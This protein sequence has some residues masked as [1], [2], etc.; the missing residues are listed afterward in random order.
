MFHGGN[1]ILGIHRHQALEV[2]RVGCDSL[3]VL[4]CGTNRSHATRLSRFDELAV[5]GVGQTTCCK[6]APSDAHQHQALD[7]FRVAVVDQH[8]QPGA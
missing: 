8:G 4:F 2:I 5:V 7:D 3:L 6:G 1:V